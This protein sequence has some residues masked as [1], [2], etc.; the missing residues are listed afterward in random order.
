MKKWKQKNIFLGGKRKISPTAVFSVPVN[1]KCK[2]DHFIQQYCFYMSTT[3]GSF[4]Y[5]GMTINTSVNSVIDLML[6]FIRI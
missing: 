2:E 4:D 3:D 5:A 1:I 6:H